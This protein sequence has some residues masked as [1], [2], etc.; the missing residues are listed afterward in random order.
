MVT[1]WHTLGFVVDQP[2]GFVETERCDTATI[3]LLTPSLA[4]VD[5]PQG[6]GG[7]PRRQALAVTFE[8]IAPGAAVTLAYLSGPT[9]SPVQR[10]TAGPVTVGPTGPSATALAR[11][12]ITYQTG[13]VGE[14]LNDEVTIGEQASGQQWT[15][16]ITANTVARKKAA[17]ALVLDRSGQ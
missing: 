13:P 1:K 12:F 3:T 6:Y 15:I 10:Y 17:S 7:S 14:V 5:V 16:D 4:F 2:E 9:A 8:V 11:F